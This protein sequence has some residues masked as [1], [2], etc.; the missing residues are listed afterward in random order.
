MD[1]LYKKQ[2]NLNV[3]TKKI[4]FGPNMNYTRENFFISILILDSRDFKPIKDFNEL[5]YLNFGLFQLKRLNGTSYVE[6]TTVEEEPCYSHEKIYRENNYLNNY[7]SN[8]L[9]NATCISNRL[10]NGREY[11]LNGS[12]LA[13][14]FNQLRVSI[15]KC[16]QN[17]LNEKF[18]VGKRRCKNKTEINDVLS[19]SYFEV[20][21]L[22]NYVDFKNYTAPKRK[23]FGNYYLRMDQ[24]LTVHGIVNFKQIKV[25]TDRGFLSEVLDID[26]FFAFESSWT[27]KSNFEPN[28]GLAYV[29]FVSSLNTQSGKRT[30]TKIQDIA[31]RVNGIFKL[32]FV[33]G[34]VFTVL[35]ASYSIYGTCIE[36]LF[37]YKYEG[38]SKFDCFVKDNKNGVMKRSSFYGCRKMGNENSLGKPKDQ[39]FEDRRLIGDCDYFGI[40]DYYEIIEGKEEVL[41]N[42]DLLNAKCNYI[43]NSSEI[44]PANKLKKESR[45]S[46]VIQKQENNELNENRDEMNY[47]KVNDINNNNNAVN[48]NEKIELQ[49][50]D[51]REQN[52]KN[53]K[54]DISRFII[55][56]KISSNN[57]IKEQAIE[58]LPEENQEE[59]KNKKIAFNDNN[60]LDPQT[61]RNLLLERIYY[62]RLNLNNKI[63]NISNINNDQNGSAGNDSINLGKNRGYLT[64]NFKKTIEMENLEKNKSH[65]NNAE[66]NLNSFNDSDRIILKKGF[67]L[68]VSKINKNTSSNNKSDFLIEQLNNNTSDILKTNKNSNEAGF[69]EHEKKAFKIISD[70]NNELNPKLIISNNNTNNIEN[71][72][73]KEEFIQKENKIKK[74]LHE[75]KVKHNFSI[76]DIFKIEIKGFCRNLRLKSDLNYKRNKLLNLM[77]YLDFL[78]VLSILRDSIYLKSLVLNEKELSAFKFFNSSVN[79]EKNLHINNRDIKNLVFIKDN[80]NWNS[81]SDEKGE[82]H[83]QK[84]SNYYCKG[85]NNEG[86]LV[87]FENPSLFYKKELIDIL[88]NEN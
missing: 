44:N 70:N 15:H 40:G 34:A 17:K 79:L 28:L 29:D 23:D 81:K 68:D 10:S 13:N 80:L 88:V 18:G 21:F 32:L 52:N 19:F 77:K 14:E 83:L 39:G 69:D 61:R 8:Y 50:N 38:F 66:N 26:T 30:Y 7:E 16:D 75:S 59:A 35:P 87:A 12:F 78:N 71:F 82:D 67:D 3:E 47:G 4:S 49:P 6:W 11:S 53:K 62:K 33:I 65:L 22:D 85:N 72:I 46:H 37:N 41:K 63:K 84:K 51:K 58:Q 56:K 20:Y 42:G 76:W 5:F 9:F 27:D 48:N 86:F 45:E 31:G 54:L 74:H 25:E 55:A 1:I 64:D 36:G 73:S 2:L 60:E 43:Q 24:V 57:L